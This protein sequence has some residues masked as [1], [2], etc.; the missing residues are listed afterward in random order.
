M[1][2]APLGAVLRVLGFICLE[3]SISVNKNSSGLKDDL[4]FKKRN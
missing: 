2:L 3:S 4:M 1:V